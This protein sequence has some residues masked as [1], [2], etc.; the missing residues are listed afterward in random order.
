MSNTTGEV[1]GAYNAFIKQHQKIAKE[2]NT[3][4]KASLILFDNKYE[5]VYIGK[6]IEKVPELDSNTYYARGLTALRD[7]IGNTINTFKNKK[8]VIFFIETDGFENASKEF[9]QEDIQKLVTK[10][11][12]KGWDFNFVGADLNDFHT[13]SIA[14]SLGITKAMAFVKST[15]GYAVRNASFLSATTA[16]IEKN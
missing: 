8:K 3:K 15:E 6:S 10:Y 16:Y 11:T 4:I 12:K 5:E 1:I 9:T 7:A 13:G 2:T 14:G